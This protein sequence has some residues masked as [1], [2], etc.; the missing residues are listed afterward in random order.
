MPTIDQISTDLR[1]T[2]RPTLGSVQAVTTPT[3]RV[4][5]VPDAAMVLFRR[6]G[7]KPPDAGPFDPVELDTKLAGLSL[8]ERF[9]AKSYLRD[10][11]LLPLGRPVDTR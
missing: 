5:V 10:A 2:A 1:A 3:D 9:A 4:V 7:L 8:G 6:I 11:G